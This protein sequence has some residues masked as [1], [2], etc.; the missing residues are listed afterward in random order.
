M[1][2]FAAPLF[3]LLVALVATVLSDRP[4]P[5]ADF[6]F[7]NRGDV[8]TLDLQR[9]SWLQDFRIA[10]ALWEPLVRNDPFTPDYC[11]IPGVAERWESSPDGLVWTFH[12][13]RNARWSDGSPVVAEDFRY[14]WRRGLLPDVAGDYVNM[15][16]VFKGAKAWSDWR[17]QAQ[18]EFA[19]ASAGVAR[20]DQAEALWRETIERY[21]RDVGVACPD[22]HTLVLTLERPVPYFLEV[23]AFEAMMPIHPGS[24]DASLTIDPVTALAKY[25]A[26]WTR[27]PNLV[28]NGPF[29]LSDWRFKRDMRLERN[30]H[31]W[32]PASIHIDSIDVPSI[33]DPGASVLTYQTGGADWLSDVTPDYRGDMILQKRAYYEEHRDE[34]HRLKA[35]GLD[36]VA[37][38]R[39]LP[40]DER[41]NLHALPAFGTYF[42]NLNCRPTLPDGRA[43]PLADRRIRKALA[44]TVDKAAIATGIRRL[45]EPAARVLIPPGSLA[46]YPA[47][48]GLPCAPDAGAIAEARRLLAEAGYPGGRG[49]MTIEILFNKDAGHDL[50]AQSVK[51][52]WERHLGIN[53][54][55]RQKEV[56][57]FRADL[58][59]HNYMVSRAGWFGDYGDPTTFLDIHRTGDGNNDRGF[60]SAEFDAMLDAAAAE[61]DPARRLSI[62]ADAERLLVEVELPFIPIHHYNQVYMFDA[63]RISG[64]SPHP[65]QKQ[66]LRL[67]DVLGDGKGRETPLEMPPALKGAG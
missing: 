4:R 32:D 40:A 16:S 7:I 67:I 21:R 9:M 6:V 57:V 45:E 38:D 44:L 54:A 10:S 58:K 59:A 26:A 61:P 41:Q 12:L 55:L 15:Y 22:D 24:A 39:R 36:P 56:Q 46:G 53:V 37:I 25:D 29:M 27:P 43:N 64:I 8:A 48:A 34:Y 20:P 14:A 65:R 13:R 63:R 52:D 62:L 42:Y 66:Y 28:T 50:I 11:K 49:L 1:L 31:Y 2:R 3:L 35:M 47:P 18:R 51:K 60:S 5:R 30:P 23:I 33:N 17:R 19:R